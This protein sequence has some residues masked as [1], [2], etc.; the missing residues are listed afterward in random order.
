MAQISQQFIEHIQQ[1]L[2]ESVPLDELLSACQCPLR[3][4]IRANLLK[5]SSQELRYELESHGYKL[6]PI[7]WC[8]EGFWVDESDKVLPDNLGN[9][10]PHLEGQCYIQ[11]ASSM[12]PVKALLHDF[13]YSKDSR[14]LDMAAAP[15]S[16]TTQLTAQINNQGLVVANEL[17]SSRLKGLHYNVQ[18][19]GVTNSVLCHTDGRYFG[20][21]TPEF[22]DAILLDAPCGGEGTVRK[23]EQALVNWSIDAVRSIAELQ[24]ELI[25]SA[26]KALKP[27]GRLVYSTC[28]L[29]KEENQEVCQYLLDLYGDNIRIKSL[30]ALFEGAEKALTQEG[31]L[32]IYPN[33]YDCEGFFVACFEKQSSIKTCQ[34]TTSSNQ[35]RFNFSPIS[36]DNLKATIDHANLFGWELTS[37]QSQLWQKDTPGKSQEIWYLP[38]STQTLSQHI[39]LNRYGIKLM[40]LSKHGAKLHHQAA[41]SFGH[42]FTQ[43]RI[44]LTSQQAEDFY[45]GK[46]IFLELAVAPPKYKEMM[47]TY[48]SIPLGL[49]KHLGNKLKNNLPRDLVRDKTFYQLP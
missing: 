5:M 37:I 4:S 31:Y 38:Q 8:D 43:Q 10:L 22:F 42:E 35:S 40:E 1:Q 30:E 2:P 21:R 3:K 45:Q 44:E 25:V 24:K 11:E 6:L 17:S 28:T 48:K 14:F 49:I 26:Y 16:K 27:G 33:L 34:D 32:H 36:A 41:I 39:K 12:L 15:G 47:V 18:R 23:D 9:W 46:D 20:D 29:S 7:P 19:C 13:Q